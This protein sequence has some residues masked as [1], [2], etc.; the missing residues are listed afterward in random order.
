MSDEA[1]L[2]QLRMRLRDVTTYR[3]TAEEIAEAESQLGFRLPSFLRRTFEEVNDGRVGPGYGLL[4]LFA[5]TEKTMVEVYKRL[6]AAPDWSPGLLPICEWGC[7]VWSCLDCRT[8]NGAIV[9]LVEEQGFFDK[10]GDLQS[11]LT[12][13]LA[14]VDL[15]DEMFEPGQPRVVANPFT[16]AVTEIE[17]KGPPRGQKWLGLV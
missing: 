9:T 1:L 3:V 11:W 2:R 8:N 14:G 13:W 16:K 10:G 7:A 17:V 5:K 4:P 15:W 12:A 6:S